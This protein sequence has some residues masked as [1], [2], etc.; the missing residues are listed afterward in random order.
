[1]KKFLHHVSLYIQKY[2]A[3]ISGYI[4]AISLNAMK[5]WTNVPVGLLVPVAMMLIMI[6]EGSQRLEDKKT[7]QAL[8][9]KND[10]N[11]QDEEILVEMI[12]HL[13]SSK[14][15]KKNVRTKRTR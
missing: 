12:E 6:G 1:M 11:K 10:P 13:E 4:S 7:V 5:Y 14:K 15:G 2:P 9:T 3:R 8:Y